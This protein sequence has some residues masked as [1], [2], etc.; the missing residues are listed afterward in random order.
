MRKFPKLNKSKIPKII[1]IGPKMIRD[2]RHPSNILVR[3]RV[4]LV[5]QAKHKYISFGEIL[6]I[7]QNIYHEYKF[8]SLEFGVAESFSMI[9]NLHFYL[10]YG[11]KNECRKDV[12]RIYQTSE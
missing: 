8:I 6:K 9:F 3:L 4:K 1:V 7:K 11:I 5:S 12:K 2:Y 10:A